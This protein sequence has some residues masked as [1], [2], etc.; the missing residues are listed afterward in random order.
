MIQQDKSG[1]LEQ[2]AG[3]LAFTPVATFTERQSH[4]SADLR[5]MPSGIRVYAK[6]QDG[7]RRYGGRF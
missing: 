2:Q 4:D 1:R 3:D 5:E 6:R 7:Q